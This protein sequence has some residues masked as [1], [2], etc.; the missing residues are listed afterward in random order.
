MSSD[1]ESKESGQTDDLI[2]EAE[3]LKSMGNSAMKT[4]NLEEAHRLYT[5]AID[6]ISECHESCPTLYSQ[7]FGNRAAVELARN[8]CA[9]AVVDCTRAL[10]FEPSNLK[11]YWRGAKASLQLNRL[12]E[13]AAFC[14]KGLNIDPK[15][16]DLHDLKALV[17][18]RNIQLKGKDNRGFTQDEAISCQNLVNQLKEQMFLINQ[19]IQAHEFEAA[20]NSRTI[21]LV[22][23]TPDS[24][25]LYSA[26]GR[27]FIRVSRESVFKGLGDRVS[28]IKKTDLPECIATRQAIAK[29]LTEAETELNEMIEYFKHRSSE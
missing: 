2:N 15:N 19:K 16:S 28:D 7:L 29:R 4:F 9:A 23:Q 5:Q 18:R 10:E 27:G 24:A 6:V 3:R 20:R 8:D 11:A 21:S 1:R 25:P 13:A 17:E 12:N 14:E 26:V 22:D